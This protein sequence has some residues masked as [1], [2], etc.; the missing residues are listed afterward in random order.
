MDCLGQL[1]YRPNPVLE[2]ALDVLFLLHADHELNAST[3][4]V[5]Q[6]ASSLTDPYSAISYVLRTACSRPPLTFVPVPDVPRFS[7]LF[8][9]GCTSADLPLFSQRPLAWYVS[10]G[11]CHLRSTLLNGIGGANEAVIRMLIAI[12]TPDKVPEFIEQVKRREKVLSGFGHRV[13][14]V[15][16]L[17]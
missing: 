12:G 1:D 6:A 10:L 4:T 7:M 11:Q 2:K 3:T 13:Y 15:C 8:E 16:H 14:K 5:L 9:V 17:Y